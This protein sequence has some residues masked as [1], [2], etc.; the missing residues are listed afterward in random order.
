[1]P[2][3][4]VKKMAHKHGTTPAEAESRWKRAKKQASKQGH[5][6]DFAY[7]TGVF[8]HMMGE[9]MLLSEGRMS[10]I[11]A[12]IDDEF[13]KYARTHGDE[14]T[15]SHMTQAKKHIAG[16]VEKEFNV[17]PANAMQLV[18]SAIHESFLSEST[19][20]P[21]VVDISKVGP[22]S[23]YDETQTNDEIHDGD[24]VICGKGN[25]G[26][27]VQ[28]WPVC[29]FGTI[30]HFHKLDKGYS[31]DTLDD[32]KYKKSYEL[33]K[34]QV[35]GNVK[36]SGMKLTFKDYLLLGEDSVEDFLKAG[37]KIQHI[38]SAKPRKSEQWQGS[39]H[40]G[41]LGGHTRSSVSGK[42]TKKGSVVIGQPKGSDS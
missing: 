10:E 1:M 25:I 2:T 17:K 8:K 5:A 29:V 31:W 20:N 9:G 21:K 4:F 39:K 42:G 3:A 13:D 41:T 11:S 19:K 33:A 22:E 15:A 28:A 7:V 40:I 34:Q 27:L 24:V 12:F 26:I 37:G 16:K 23:Y 38:K 14:W 6:E 35:G 18:S 32:G 30:P 36:E